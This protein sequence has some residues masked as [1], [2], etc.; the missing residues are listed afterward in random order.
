MEDDR[1][2]ERVMREFILSINEIYEQKEEVEQ[3][4]KKIQVVVVHGFIM[5]KI[6]S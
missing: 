5:V 6:T 2:R 4:W 1:R 3:K